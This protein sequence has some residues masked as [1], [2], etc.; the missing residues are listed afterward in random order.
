LD[1][2]PQSEIKGIGDLRIIRNGQLV[3]CLSPC[4]KWNYPY[5]YGL[6]QP[7]TVSPG[8]DMCCPTPPISPQQCSSGPVI[9]TNFVNQVRNNCPSA[10]SYAYDDQAGLVR[11]LHQKWSYILI[12]KN[13]EIFLL[14]I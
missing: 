14:S 10:Y 2:C 7:E 5:P 1:K 13:V 11:L 4:K 8:L 3:G 9:Q 12:S 6:G